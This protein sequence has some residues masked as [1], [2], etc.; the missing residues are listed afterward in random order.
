VEVGFHNNSRGEK[1]RQ[2]TSRKEFV[3]YPNREHGFYRVELT[4]GAGYFSESYGSN[5]YHNAI[6]LS[7]VS[8]RIRQY[9]LKE[10]SR[11]LDLP[12][13]IPYFVRRHLTFGFLD[14]EELNRNRP[15]TRLLQFNGRFIR[16]Q[17][18][19]LAKSGL[20]PSILSQ[21]T[22]PMRLFFPDQGADA[23]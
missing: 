9:Q 8:P 3:R 2:N 21:R 19:R 11:T 4:V 16:G 20:M 12:G 7:D 14:L 18:N 1:R 10:R 22:P 23:S 13:F 5:A 6:E 17:R 15:A